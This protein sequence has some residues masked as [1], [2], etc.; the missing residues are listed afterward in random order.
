MSVLS[1][2]EVVIIGVSDTPSKP[3]GRVET[4]SNQRNAPPRAALYAVQQW[5]EFSTH[6]PGRWQVAQHSAAG[7]PGEVVRSRARATR[8]M[9]SGVGAGGGG[10]V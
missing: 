5:T 2:A 9:C 8:L 3:V 4:N 10:A 7:S 1:G 6:G